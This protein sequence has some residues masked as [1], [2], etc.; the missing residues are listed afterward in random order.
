MLRPRYWLREPKLRR[1]LVD[2]P[3][4]DPPHK[5]EER[6]LPEDKAREN[7]QYFL[8][9]R[10]ERL[11]FFFGWLERQFGVQATL[12][13]NGLEKLLDW[14]RDYIGLLLLDEARGAVFMEYAKPWTGKYAGANALFDIGIAVGEAI[15]LRR[16][17]LSWHMEWSLAR[18]PEWERQASLETKRIVQCI[19][20]EERE[21]KRD[22]RSGFRRP[23]L[24]SSTNPAA[25]KPVFSIIYSF[26]LMQN[27]Y[28][29][30][31]YAW[32]EFRTPKSLRSQ[33][34]LKLRSFVFN[35]ISIECR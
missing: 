21:R 32:K 17:D 35:A 2:Y 8:D 11:D 3:V 27:L 34:P 9:V 20:Q 6:V 5:S 13:G 16:P 1:A 4:Y 12:E 14:S 19:R 18:H 7:F 33:H 10:L 29:P 31:G 24:A 22:K 28:A 23:C 30:I 26:Y 25:Y 15:V